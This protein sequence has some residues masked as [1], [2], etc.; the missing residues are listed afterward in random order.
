MNEFGC[1]RTADGKLCLFFDSQ[2]DRAVTWW[3]TSY[4]RH[5]WSIGRHNKYC[6]VQAFKLIDLMIWDEGCSK[7]CCYGPFQSGVFCC[8]FH[9]TKPKLACGLERGRVCLFSGTHHSTPFSEWTETLLQ[10]ATRS[11]VKCVDWKVRHQNSS[12]PN[13]WQWRKLCL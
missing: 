13:V 1:P 8:S 6:Q 7:R 10:A 2:N 11:W 4:H 3:K 12:C 9:P 5:L